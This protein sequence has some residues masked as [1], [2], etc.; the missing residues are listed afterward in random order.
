MSY[1]FRHETNLFCDCGSGLKVLSHSR[2][3]KSCECYNAAVAA[4]QAAANS[5]AMTRIHHPMQPLR[6][7]LNEFGAFGRDNN[8]VMVQ[9]ATAEEVA[10]F[11]ALTTEARKASER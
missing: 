3:C 11:S 2:M 7:W 8:G 4:Q 1:K 5:L 9:V 6:A 10:P